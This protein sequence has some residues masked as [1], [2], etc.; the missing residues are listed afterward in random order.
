MSPPDG[1]SDDD[2]NALIRSIKEAMN[3]AAAKK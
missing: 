1:A 2:I 3:Q